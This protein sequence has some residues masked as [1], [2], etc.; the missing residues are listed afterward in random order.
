[1][2]VEFATA[3]TNCAE[4]N[5]AVIEKMANVILELDKS[6][7]GNTLVTN[8]GDFILVEEKVDVETQRAT[9]LKD[10]EK[11]QFE[12]DRSSKMLSNEKFIAKAPESLVLAEKEKLEKNTALLNS[13]KEKLS[14]L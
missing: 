5:K 3:K 12:I 13:L 14:K 4:T 10:I 6:E 2:K 9:L 1:D 8:V 7:E 11:V